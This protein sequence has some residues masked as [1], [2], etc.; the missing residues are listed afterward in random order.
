[1]A[2][3][4]ITVPPATGSGWT[5]RSTASHITAPMA[6][7]RNTALNRAARIEEPRSP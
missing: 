5:R 3:T 6:I 1:M 4:T 2:A 7:S